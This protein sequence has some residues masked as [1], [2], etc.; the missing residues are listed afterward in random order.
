[1]SCAPDWL[2]PGMHAEFHRL[3]RDVLQRTPN[4]EQAELLGVAALLLLRWRAAV[5]RLGGCAAGSPA[6]HAA[7][8]CATT[9]YTLASAASRAACELPSIDPLH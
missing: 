2:P 6:H 3:G 4:A 5:E 9:L 8:D 7:T 1:M